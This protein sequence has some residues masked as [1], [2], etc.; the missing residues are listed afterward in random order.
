ME[1]ISH[2]ALPYLGRHLAMNKERVLSSLESEQQ[3]SKRAVSSLCIVLSNV[4]EGGT[5]IVCS[6]T[7]GGNATIKR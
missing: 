1:P 4:D 5:A 6:Q 2:A 3:R 7:A